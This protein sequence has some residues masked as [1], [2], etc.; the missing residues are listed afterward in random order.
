MP[1][2]TRRRNAV[3]PAEVAAVA[4]RAVD[5][6]Q[7]L[8]QQ[9]AVAVLDVHEV[10]PGPPGQHRGPHV[11]VDQGVEL[12]VGQHGRV[13]AGPA[14]SPPGVEQRVAVGDA[15]A[16]ARRRAGSSGPSG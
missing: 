7:Q 15:R 5:R 3:R 1:S 12:G 2:T 8:V 6:G 14:P 9:V 4:T 11:V 13:A 16:A 10:E